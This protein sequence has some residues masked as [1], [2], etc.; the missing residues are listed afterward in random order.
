M[1]ETLK[2]PLPSPP[3]PQVSRSSSFRLGVTGIALAL[4]A[5]AQPAISSAVSP[6]MRRA[7]TK[8]LIWLGVASPRIIS[9]ITASASAWAR[10]S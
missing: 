3:V 10:F 2:V 9:P 8:A 6:F 7:V 5:R 4:I 1:V